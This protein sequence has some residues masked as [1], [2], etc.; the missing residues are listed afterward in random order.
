MNSLRTILRPGVSRSALLIALGIALCGCDQLQGKDRYEIKQDSAGRTI[1]LDK[2][3][4]EIAVL[5]GEKLTPIREEAD[6][7]ATEQ[8]R[9][10]AEAAAQSKLE[11]LTLPITRPPKILQPIGVKNAT[12]YTM[13]RDG[14][15]YF[16]LGM[17]PAPKPS[18][19]SWGLGLT[20]FRIVFTDLAG[21]NVVDEPIPIASIVSV[22]DDS[23]KAGDVNVNWYVPLSQQAYE[24]I[25]D[26]TITWLQ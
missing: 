19:R 15:L 20:R 22:V 25:S 7:K 6:H 9:V 11:S 3:T 13:W 16:K 17:H 10:A 21:F 26:W 4:G 23:G 12:M 8:R 24:S 1:R 5:E 18:A 14:K 2:Q